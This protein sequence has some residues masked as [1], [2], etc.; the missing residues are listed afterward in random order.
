MRGVLSCSQF[1]VTLCDMELGGTRTYRMGARAESAAET[2][3]RI[4]DAAV[5]LFWEGAPLSLE[6]VAEAASVSVR[7]VIRRFGSKDGLMQAALVRE[8]ARTRSQRDEAPVGDVQ[9]AVAVLV[10]HYE[11]MG[12][13]VLTLLAQEDRVDGLDQIVEAGRVLHRDW[14]T[15]V[16]APTLAGLSGLERR[17]HHHLR[18]PVARSVARVRAGPRRQW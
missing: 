3:D 2:G 8:S 16:F 4:L 10:E 14:C 1:R 6:D 18:R 7:T 17:R 9:A 13:K 5:G 11:Q 15:R 12:D